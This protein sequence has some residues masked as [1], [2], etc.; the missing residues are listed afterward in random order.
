MQIICNNKNRKNILGIS[1][2]RQ[3][4]HKLFCAINLHYFLGS[5]WEAVSTVSIFH[6]AWGD[7]RVHMQ[8]YVPSRSA[9]ASWEDSHISKWPKVCLLFSP[10]G[11]EIQ[12]T[13]FCKQHGNKKKSLNKIDYNQLHSLIQDDKWSDFSERSLVKLDFKIFN[14]EKKKNLYMK[15]QALQSTK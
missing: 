15:S 1:V 4:F 13:W 5:S 3:H 8:R 2:E 14:S 12:M 6:S 9:S 10:Q 7:T 11:N